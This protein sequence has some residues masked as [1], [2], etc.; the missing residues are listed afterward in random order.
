MFLKALNGLWTHI[1][2]INSKLFAIKNEDI[3]DLQV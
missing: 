1:S 2:V 3:D